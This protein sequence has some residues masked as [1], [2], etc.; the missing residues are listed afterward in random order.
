M[1]RRT[2]LA[3]A[4][5]LLAFPCAAQTPA[6]NLLL[7][8]P[9]SL[10]IPLTASV[11]AGTAYTR[12][13]T[14]TATYLA[15]GVVTAASGANVPRFESDL[16]GGLLG[17]LSEPQAIELN[18][19]TVPQSD[20][21]H[22]WNYATGNTAG[23]VNTAD[24]TA[25]DGTSMALK[26]ADNSTSG[27]HSASVGTF[28]YT[29]G[30]T[31]DIIA[32]VRINT[33]TPSATVAQLAAPSTQFGANAWADFNVQ[34]CAATGTTGSAAT[35]F[36][37]LLANSWCQIAISAPA[38]AT[39][40]GSP[41]VVLTNNVTT[42]TRLPTYSGSGQ[43]LYLW[44]VGSRAEYV[45]TS[46]IATNGSSL[47][48]SPDNLSVALTTY[49]WLQANPQGYTVAVD[50]TV[51][52][53]VQAAGTVVPFALIGSGGAAV[54]GSY[55]GLHTNGLTYLTTNVA[56]NGVLSSGLTLAVAPASNVAVFTALPL[57]LRYSLNHATPGS[58]TQ[59]GKPVMTTLQIGGL[60]SASYANMHA[61]AVTLRAGPA[62]AGQLQAMP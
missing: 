2:L 6:L 53:N 1:L 31:Y 11:P 41:L 7:A 20:T 33:T 52:A 43:Y 60:A 35:A 62:S 39:S 40:S 21:T 13:G 56:S 55:W 3:I 25:P 9:R 59:T 16:N 10:R 54:N 14:A 51:P 48:R 28:A 22:G 17:Y 34:T 57:G 47:T 44:G 12:G 36:A 18:P 32:Y 26:L 42:A 58:I 24:T 27:G 8:G 30:T 23:T 4:A 5:C 50:F 46:Y 49:P 15:N 37:K 29:S 38:T 45:P 19:Y 61:T